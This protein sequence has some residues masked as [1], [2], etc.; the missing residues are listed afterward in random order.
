M[1]S[2][3]TNGNAIVIIEC[4]DPEL[5]KPF[6]LN[7]PLVGKA[8]HGREEFQEIARVFLHSLKSSVGTRISH[9]CRRTLHLLGTMKV[10]GS[11]GVS[12]R[13]NGSK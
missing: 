5:F 3:S 4:I 2:D 6:L 12:K 13:R 10:S 7:M 1:P 8:P 9:D 11:R